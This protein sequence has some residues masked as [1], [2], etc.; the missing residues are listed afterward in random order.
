MLPVDEV[1]TI[2]LS[3][4]ELFLVER[5]TQTISLLRGSTVL[6]ENVSWT[7][8]F[9]AIATVAEWNDRVSFSG[10]T[11]ITAEYEGETYECDLTV[12]PSPAGKYLADIT[13]AEMDGAR[14]LFDLTVNEDKTYRYY[15]RES[16]EMEAG[17]VNNGTWEF[18][19]KNTIIFTY[20]GGE[21][22]MRV[23]TDGSLSSVGELPTGGMDAELIFNKETVN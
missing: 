6:T 19:D 5:D 4:T 9:P 16:T 1:Q 11:T 2:S 3:N 10:R 18:E 23:R 22:R 7:S 13:V 15:R 14:F 17:P 21:M 8:S 20:S 12:C